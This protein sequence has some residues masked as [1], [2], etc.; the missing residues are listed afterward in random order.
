MHSVNIL[1]IQDFSMPWSQTILLI[2]IP[3]AE[4]P[5]ILD[6]FGYTLSHT[7]GGAISASVLDQ[8]NIFGQED[9]FEK[10]SYSF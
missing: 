4:Y 1:H 6:M 8:T 5:E 9:A 2:S 7:S 3:R 10:S